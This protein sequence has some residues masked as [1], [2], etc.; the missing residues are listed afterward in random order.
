MT[1]LEQQHSLTVSAHNPA[2]HASEILRLDTE[3][4][5]VAK[6]VSDAEI[7][8]ERLEGELEGLRAQL[9][10]LEAQGVEGGE[11]GNRAARGAGEDEV[12]CVYSLF[13]D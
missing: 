11:A 5:R 12:M 7:E 13:A 1:A 3:K 2:E 9:T 4:F 6:G 10:E 8:G